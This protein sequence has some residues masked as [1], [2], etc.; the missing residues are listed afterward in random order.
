MK[1][2]VSRDSFFAP[3]IEIFG[4]VYRWLQANSDISPENQSEV[5]STVRLSLMNVKDLFEIVRPTGLLSS[6]ALL[7]AIEMQTVQK[8]SRNV[9][10]RG[11]LR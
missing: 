7:D 11:L 4:A 3:E 1:S 8:N 10:H 9:N 5:L 6:D 2:L